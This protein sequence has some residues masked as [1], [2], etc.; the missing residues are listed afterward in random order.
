MSNDLLLDTHV[1]IWLVDG[2][3]RGRPL[4]PVID[5]PASTVTVSAVTWFEIAVKRSVGKLSSTVAATV[6]ELAG[7]GI[8]EL[9]ITANHAEQLE[10]LPLH[11]RDPFD[12]M[13]IAQALAED[14]TI[15]SA[16]RSFGLYDDVKV[17]VP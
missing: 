1:V 4:L 15:V 7:L 2:D 5:D 11:H 13:L 10:R 8:L 14:M 12:R 16:D 3:E 17:L 6:E 9:A